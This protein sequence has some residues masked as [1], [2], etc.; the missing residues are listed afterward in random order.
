[1]EKNIN[2]P[3][4]DTCQI[5]VMPPQISDEDIFAL[6]S[7]IIGVVKRKVELETQ[8]ELINMNI[9]TEKLKKQLKEKTAECV[10]LKNQIISLK[11]RLKH[12]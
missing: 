9:N 7:G 2:T 4:K 5:H 3:T 12:D 8:A 6:L 1:M 11:A 10:R